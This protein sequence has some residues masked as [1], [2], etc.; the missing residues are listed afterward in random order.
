MAV[1]AKAVDGADPWNYEAASAIEL[2]ATGLR[3]IGDALAKI[4]VQGDP[5]TASLAARARQ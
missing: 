5:Y 3:K 4:T 2:T 1:R